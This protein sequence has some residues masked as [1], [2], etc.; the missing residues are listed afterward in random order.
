MRHALEPTSKSS[1]GRNAL[2]KSQDPGAMAGL[3]GCGDAVPLRS[4]GTRSRRLAWCVM[5]SEVASG[6]L[7][8]VGEVAKH[9]GNLFFDIRLKLLDI[10]ATADVRAMLR[11]NSF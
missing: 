5:G 9:H 6:C 10:P 11:V 3:E 2:A 7:E 8:W 4:V 1:C